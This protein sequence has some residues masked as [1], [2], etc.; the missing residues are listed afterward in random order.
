MESLIQYRDYF[1]NYLEHYRQY[2]KNTLV[3]YMKDIDEF[4]SFLDTYHYSWKEL[5]PQIISSWFDSKQHLSPRTVSRKLSVLRNFFHYL[6]TENVIDSN[7]FVLFSSPKCPTVIP[8][9]LSVNEMTHLLQD[10]PSSTILERRNQC[11]LKI[12]YATGIRSEELCS[13]KCEQVFFKQ[14]V[15]KILGKGGKMRLVPIIPPIQRDLELWF[16]ERKNLDQGIDDTVFLSNNGRRLT[17]SMIRKIVRKY[18]QSLSKNFH[19]HAFRY[20]FASHLLDNQANL[21][22][23]QEL[24]GH[25]NLSVTQRYTKISI[26]SLQ[27]KYLQFHPHAK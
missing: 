19:P 18:T 14:N 27:Q 15:I 13:L 23:I 20:T 9:T 12:M 10:I 1:L 21:R 17:T 8:T 6:M 26:S 7:V 22:C 5:S 11:I 3:A 25:A 16:E 2:S 24:L 4:I